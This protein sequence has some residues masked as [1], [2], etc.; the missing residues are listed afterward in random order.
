MNP[1]MISLHLSETLQ[2]SNHSSGKSRNT[3]HR[4]QKNTPERPTQCHFAF[5]M[6]RVKVFTK[7]LTRLTYGNHIGMET[8]FQIV[9]MQKKNLSNSQEI[10]LSNSLYWLIKTSRQVVIFIC[11]QRTNLQHQ[12]KVLIGCTN[13]T[14]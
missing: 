1:T 4:L 9:H 5:F 3:C 10:E 11:R 2:M 8:L 12:I 13:R 7:R 6:V 14:D